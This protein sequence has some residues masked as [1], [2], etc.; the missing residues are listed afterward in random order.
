MISTTNYRSLAGKTVSGPEGKIG[1]IV[2]VYESTDGGGITFATVSTGMFGTGASFFPLE[3]ATLSGDDVQVPY[4]KDFIKDAPRVD[5]DEELTSSEEAR[6]FQYY[7]PADMTAAAGTVEGSGH[8]T[9][10]P[11]TD[12]AMTRSEEE[13]RV[14]TATV[15]AGRARL[16]KYV[17]TETET[18]TVPVSHEEVHVTREPITEDNLSA[19]LD[20]PEISEEE[21]EVILHAETPVVAKETVPV[22][23]VRLETE[24]VTEQ[25]TVSA[26][27]RKEHIETDGVYPDEAPRQSA[28]ESRI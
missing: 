5:S 8:D 18:R 15:E 3:E 9:S 19:A 2:D 7:R 10:G 1:K 27:V 23:R 26:D 6:L 14:G 22:E 20:G 17:T 21:H 16:R 28:T 4:T 24:T 25:E 13:L 12:S 11:S